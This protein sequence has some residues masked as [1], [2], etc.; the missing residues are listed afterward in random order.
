MTSKTARTVTGNK[1]KFEG[2]IIIPVSLNGI[3]KKLKFFVLNN[4]EN[5]FGSDWFQKFNL[6]DQPIY[7]FCKKVECFTAEAEKIQIELKGSFPEVFSVGLGKCTKIKAKFELKENTCPI[8]RKKRNVPFPTT[9]EINKE[10]DR[11]VNMGILSKVEFND[12]A[13]PTVSIRKSSKEIQVCSDFSTGLN[14]ALKDYHYPLPSQEEVFNK[15]NGGKVF[16]KIDLSAAYLQIPLEEN[17]FKLLC[18]NDSNDVSQTEEKPIDTI[19]DMFD[20]DPPQSTP[21]IRRPG[22]KKKFTDK[23]I[24]PKRKK[25]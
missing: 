14:T 5:L 6:Y 21:E 8:F 10:L 12:W 23:L 13:A 3:S 18:I 25:Y 24:D 1:I 11:L 19:F 17:S 22:R 7:T 20:L 16:S 4:T 2:E 15:L 9:E